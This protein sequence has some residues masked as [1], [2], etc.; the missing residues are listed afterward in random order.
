[1]ATS[2]DS[3]HDDLESHIT[4]SEVYGTDDVVIMYIDESRFQTRDAISDLAKELDSLAEAL[5]E[6]GLNLHYHNHDHEFVDVDGTP[7]LSRLVEETS[8]LGFELDLG[9]AGT[10]GV[11]PAEF[12]ASIQDRVTHVHIK[13]MAFESREFVTFGEGDLDIEQAVDAARSVDVEWII[14]ENDQPNDPAAEISHASLLL[15]QYTGHL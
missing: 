12:L 6:S 1:M 13:D 3:L 8:Q 4:A 7:A 9:W 14:F 5:A 2:P 11:D 15:N 10:G